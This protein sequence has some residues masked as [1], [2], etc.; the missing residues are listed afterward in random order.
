MAEPDHSKVEQ[1]E[2]KGSDFKLERYKFILQ[3]VHTLNDNLHKYL[4]L[5]QTLTT[6]IFGAGVALFVSWRQLN[7]TVEVAITAMRGLLALL[8]ILTLF[9]VS[10]LIAGILS[11]FDYRWE[12]VELLNETV[13]QG[14]RK[15]PS[16]KNFW[17]W[18]ETYLIVFILIVVVAIAIYV[19]TQVVPQM[20]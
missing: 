9:V 17:R 14:F 13:K 19:E 4:A 5:F 16:L 10:S 20:L 6:A 8:I 18:Y 3:E 7:I 12:E 11:W 15:P 2:D 1:D